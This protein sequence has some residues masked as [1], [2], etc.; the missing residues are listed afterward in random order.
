M[1]QPASME[2]QDK[3]DKFLEYF[4]QL[5]VQKLAAA[6]IGVH[7]NTIINWKNEDC[8]FCDQVEMA[9]AEWALKNVKQVRSRE[10]LLERLLRDQFGQNNQV[11]M[12]LTQ[13]NYF[14]LNDEQLDQLIQS[15][16]RQVGA[17][18]VANGKGTEDSGEP[19]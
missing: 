9:K 6:S 12:N 18:A 10:W 7:E 13:N 17:G 19:A 2:N 16:I 15:K 11:G 8:D 3:K 1:R 5:P 4:K 14:N